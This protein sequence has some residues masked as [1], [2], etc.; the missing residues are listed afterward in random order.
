MKILN[1]VNDELAPINIAIID[2]ECTCEK[3][4]S[5]TPSEIIEIGSVVGRLTSESLSITSELQIYVKPTINPT[6][7]AF[8]TQL[9]GIIQYTVDIADP[10]PEALPLLYDWLQS[11]NVAAWASWGK[12]DA[13]QLSRECELKSVPN[14]MAA[15]QHFNLKQ[16]F[17]RKFKQ[18]VGLGRALELRSLNF[19]G[20]PH[21]GIDD[22][23]NIA[24]LIS[25][26][27][28]LRD[29]IL[30]RVTSPAST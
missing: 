4:S 12:F 25:N 18:R 15:I 14:P 13:T 3:D 29:A 26:E 1:A 11:N 8:C 17:A 20:V 23:K 6:L 24:N 2:L 27:T 21:S 7:T 9:T 22:A 30:K 10:L 16:L 5:L 19:K 28:L